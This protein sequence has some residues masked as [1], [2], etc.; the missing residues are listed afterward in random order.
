MDMTVRFPGGLVV[1]A[2]WKGHVIRTD[3]PEREG[4]TNT[5][6]APFDLFLASIATCAGLYAYRFCQERNIPT[7]ALTVGMDVERDPEKKRIAALRI[8]LGLP[9]G[10][11][12]KYRAAIVRAVDT[13]AV[14]RHLHEPPEIEVA[15]V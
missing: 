8:R 3:Q 2:G 10:F 15:L 9:P 12:E 1:E 4:G 11:P 5:A 13:C 6:P 7:D 14:K